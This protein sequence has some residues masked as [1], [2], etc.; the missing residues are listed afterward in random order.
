MSYPESSLDPVIYGVGQGVKLFST[1][2]GQVR[3]LLTQKETQLTPTAKATSSIADWSWEKSYAQG[4]E[5]GLALQQRLQ[6][7]LRERRRL[8]GRRAPRITSIVCGRP[9]LA[10][11]PRLQLG[12]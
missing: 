3:D 8:E 6:D 5:E 9:V 7:E 1:I 2:C 4:I 12:R 11:S 10:A